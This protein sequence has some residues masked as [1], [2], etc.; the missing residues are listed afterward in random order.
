[1]DIRPATTDDIPALARLRIALLEETGGAMAEVARADMLRL[2][3]A[4]FRQQM[5]S[6]D[7]SHWLAVAEGHVVAAASLA[8]FLRPPYPGNPEGRDAYFLNMYTLPAWR[9]RGAARR[10]LNACLQEADGHG[11]RKVVLHATE[12]GRPLYAQAGFL[13]SS[14]YMEWTPA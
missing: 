12:A 10:I 14:A 6:A 7:W 5:P 11:V 13:P 8:Y 9:G 2:N 1:M 4:F 3:E